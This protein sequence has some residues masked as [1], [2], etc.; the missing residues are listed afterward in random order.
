MLSKGN[1][2]TIQKLPF[3]VNTTIELKN[4]TTASENNV[5]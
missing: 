2:G 1:S 5:I 3:G 4:V